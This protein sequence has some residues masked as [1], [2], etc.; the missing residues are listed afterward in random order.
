[1]LETGIHQL[2]YYS[3]SS[4]TTVDDYSLAP[5]V[6]LLVVD[7]PPSSPPPSPASPPPP[8]L[9]SNAYFRPELTQINSTV[10]VNLCNALTLSSCTTPFGLQLGGVGSFI[11]TGEGSDSCTGASSSS[12]GGVI[13]LIGGQMVIQDVR[14]PATGN[15]TLCASSSNSVAD[16]DY[17]PVSGS[18]L[19]VPSVALYYAD[20][21][22][23]FPPSA[24]GADL[25][26]RDGD[27]TGPEGPSQNFNGIWLRMTLHTYDNTEL[28]PEETVTM[29]NELI[30]NLSDGTNYLEG[31]TVAFETSM[32][33]LLNGTHD[34]IDLGGDGVHRRLSE[35]DVLGEYIVFSIRPTNS[36]D[37]LVITENA[38]FALACAIQ[39]PQFGPVL[40]KY[41]I[42]T[43]PDDLVLQRSD[44]SW[45][46]CQ[47]EIC[48]T[49]LWQVWYNGSQ[50]LV[51]C[52]SPPSPPSEPPSSPSG[53]PSAPNQ[54]VTDLDGSESNVATGDGSSKSEDWQY[55]LL[56]AVAAVAVGICLLL[57][58]LPFCCFATAPDERIYVFQ[59]P[60][61]PAA[62]T[63]PQIAS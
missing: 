23:P 29:V 4:P 34:P 10:D 45:H 43:T 16:S 3:A 6:T 62:K 39:D 24:P 59:L 58:L 7:R 28:T 19:V 46:A 12:A 18:I 56:A 48:G 33:V 55:V 37:N 35:G 14:F 30:G 26:V 32:S 52:S 5:V 54:F 2:C 38:K 51:D 50:V 36:T 40:D 57:C 27:Y 53:P 13:E 11:P 60:D 9:P 21:G 17:S 8:P 20:L 1:M 41:G 25:P 61:L 63:Q 31:Q 22:F 49:D 47:P 15:Y 42:Q 44:P